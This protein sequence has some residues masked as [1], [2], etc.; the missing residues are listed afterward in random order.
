MARTGSRHSKTLALAPVTWLRF[1]L[2]WI[3]QVRLWQGTLFISKDFCPR[4]RVSPVASARNELKR[5][6]TFL[7][8]GFDLTSQGNR[9]FHIVYGY[10]EEA[11]VPACGSRS[12]CSTPDDFFTA[13]R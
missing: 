11:G 2:L 3:K 1:V 6:G 12:R 13:L 5:N 4:N 9:S 7:L 8:E 10:V